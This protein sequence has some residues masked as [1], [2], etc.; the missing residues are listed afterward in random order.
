MEKHLHRN[1]TGELKIGNRIL[2]A[3]PTRIGVIGIG[4]VGSL[5]AKNLYTGSI[6]GG[7]LS[8]VCDIDP[9]RLKW[10]YEYFGDS[11]TL[12]DNYESLL[13]SKSVDGVIVATPHYDHPVIAIKAFEC[14]LNVLI[15]KPAGVYT[16]KVAEMNQVA[17]N[18][19]KVFG[20]MFNQRT[21]PI[22]QKVRELVQNGELGSI[23][24]SNWIIT[25]WYRPQSYYD[26]GKWRATWAGEGGGV[27]LNQA[28]HQLDLWQWICG[29]PKRVRAFIG[30]GKYHHI[31]VDDDV[32]IYVE[33]E[34]GATGLF[35]TSTHETPGTDRFEISGDL[36]KLVVEDDKLTFLRNRISERKFNAEWAYGD[37]APEYWK[38]EVPITGAETAHKG[39]LTN[40]VSAIRNRTTLLAPGIEGI[41]SLMI[42]NACYLSSWLDQRIVLPIDE[43]LFLSMLNERITNS[44]YKL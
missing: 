32:T 7:E 10:A 27:L 6:P 19:G 26:S 33:Y 16:K 15:E 29:M 44:R 25:S 24:R 18:S 40:W 13:D 11:V 35:V 8:A 4:N 30:Y 12:F 17:T 22:Y 3:S 43:N 36:G 34:N 39:I 41:N 5:H 37:G 42:S 21:N 1:I 23:K 9:M 31:E 28:P 14:G 20:I 2:E 38:C